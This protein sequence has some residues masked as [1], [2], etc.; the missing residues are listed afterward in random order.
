MIP[1]PPEWILDVAHNAAGGG[2]ARREPRRAAR[3]RGA[4]SPSAASSPTRTSRRS[5][6]RS[7]RRCDRWIAVGLDGPRALAARGTRAPDRPGGRRVGA[8][9]SRTSPRAFAQARVEMRPGRPRPR[10]R[11]VPDGR[12]RARGARRGFVTARR[13]TIGRHGSARAR[14][15]D[16]GAGAGRHRGAVRARHPE[17]PRHRAG[18]TPGPA[19]PT[20]RD[21]GR[22][23][24][25]VPEEQVL[26]P[27]P[28]PTLPRAPQ[29]RCPQPRPASRKRETRG[30]RTPAPVPAP[31]RRHARSREPHAR[32]PNR[33]AGCRLAGARLGGS[34][35]RILE[36]RESRAARR[37]AAQAALRGVPARV[38]RAGQVLYRV[39]VGP[40]QDRARAE[41]IAA[42][43]AKDGFQPVVARHP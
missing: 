4:R 11:L 30:R 36:P 32:Q 17:G 8:S 38:P 22:D 13:A 25:P 12:A 40:E 2:V 18:A 39:R 14:T 1:G 7:R 10:V 9:P 29:P 19:H 27:E 37:G 24:A 16:R 26:V 3:A 41:E 6:R 20:R 42:R 15:A 23:A 31:R 5:S 34:A 21:S 28:A 35:R 43:L 33:A